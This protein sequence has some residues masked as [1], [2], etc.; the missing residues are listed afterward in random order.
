MKASGDKSNGYQAI[1]EDFT[2]AR[3]VSIG[4]RIV[5]KWAKALKPGASVLDIGCGS[6]VPISEVLL[7][8][9]LTVYGVD[10]SE[11]LAA[12]FRGRFPNANVECSSVAESLFFSRTFD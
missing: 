2:R 5:R 8:E 4:P 3:T 11:T 9:G 6:G 10:G 1:A 12:K 7:Q